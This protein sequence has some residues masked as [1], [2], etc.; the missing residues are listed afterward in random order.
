MKQKHKA[1]NRYVAFC[2]V[3]GFK[4]VVISEELSIVANRYSNLILEAYNIASMVTI[5]KLDYFKDY[6]L[7]FAIFSDTIFAWSE[8]FSNEYDDISKYDHTFLN[9]ISLLFSVG[10]KHNLPF[11]IGIAYG[12]CIIQPENNLYLGMPLINAYQ[13]EGVQEW[14]GIGCHP[15]CLE[16]P[17]NSQLC[18]TTSDG[19]EQG[20]LIPYKVP[21]KDQCN[22]VLNYTLD[23]P[24]W[25]ENRE[26]LVKIIKLKIKETKKMKYILKW[27]RCLEYFEH[28]YDQLKDTRDSFVGGSYQS[29]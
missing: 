26:K 11:R 1:E 8:S 20:L 2:D 3:L 23:W 4:N 18:F 29:P 6:K 14:I 24:R 12:E 19:I 25:I 13:T 10:L 27:K 9:L 5:P 22:L 28:R 16:S 17:I 21:I 7:N 15:S